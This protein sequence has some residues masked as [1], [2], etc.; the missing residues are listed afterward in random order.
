MSY[1]RTIATEYG[2]VR[3]IVKDECEL[4]LGI[5]FAAPP[6]GDL[7]FKHPV[8][9]KSWKGV[10][11]V[12]RAPIS[13]VQ[14]KGRTAITADGKDCLY[15]NVFVPLDLPADAPVMVWFYGGSYANGGCG[16]ISD[17][18]DELYYDLLKYAKDTKTVVVTF[19]YRLNLE[20]F[21][22]LNFINADFDRNNGLYDQMAALKFVRNNINKFG[23]D[24]DN[25][26]VFGQSAGAACIL[27]LLGMEEARTLFDKAIMQS[28]CALSF[29]SEKQSKR[30]T[31][32]YLS[33]LGVK[34][35]ELNKLKDLDVEAI[36]EANKKLRKFV[37]KE[38]ESNCAFSPVIDGMTIKDDP[39]QLA[40]ESNKPILIG[41]CAQEGDAFIN[42][43]KGPLLPL[44]ASWF[45][46]KLKWSKDMRRIMS[47]NFTDFFYKKPSHELARDIKGP[48]WVYEYRHM[49][50]DIE[51]RGAGCFHASE[52]PVLFDKSTNYCKVE[53]PVS[54][55]VGEK[56]REY[57]SAFAYTGKL[58]WTEF[59]ENEEVKGIN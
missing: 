49:T 50:P 53:D 24:A 22:N 43:I 39:V 23:G 47:D 12:A 45:G 32:K 25:V 57:W 56:M 14:G 16:R 51:K 37:F 21:L 44:A 42:G 3:G 26:T 30:Y 35:T 36:H 11:E 59:K 19:N 15:L 10:L 1:S 13:P 58:P 34:I 28:P 46:F 5:P 29:W 41:T 2:L 33:F 20:G 9:P 17:E 6:V 54:K 40:K 55:R 18:S 8:P 48:S 52:L 31:H 7:A 27:A 4:Y 38:G